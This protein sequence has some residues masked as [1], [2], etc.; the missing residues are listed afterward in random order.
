MIYGTRHPKQY[1]NPLKLKNQLHNTV[2]SVCEDFDADSESLEFSSLLLFL[3][4]TPA[5]SG[6]RGAD[7]QQKN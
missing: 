2:Y 5:V 4:V 6:V 3:P 7:E 1:D